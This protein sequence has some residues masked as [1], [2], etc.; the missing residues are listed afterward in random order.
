MASAIRLTHLALPVS[1]LDESIRFYEDNV[2]L[3]V[4]D[5]RETASGSAK[6]ARLTD[7]EESFALVLIETGRM[8]QPLSGLTHVGL[9]L[10]S[11]DDVDRLAGSAKQARRLR[12]GPTDAGEPPGYSAMLTDP[13]GHQVELTHDQDTGPKPLR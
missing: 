13:D 2:D 1:N 8:V 5:Q 11:R 7:R 6:T 9:S 10:P 4:V 3:K 12:S